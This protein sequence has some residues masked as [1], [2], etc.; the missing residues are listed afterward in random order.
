MKTTGIV[1][2]IVILISGAVRADRPLEKKE[3]SQILQ[4]LTS[5][6]MKA[7]I[8]SGTISAIHEEYRAPKIT[9][10]G[11][12]NDRI[13][14]AIREHQNEARTS[15]LSAD[16]LKM[17]LDAIPFNVRYELSNE[18]TMNSD[19][20]I[21]YDGRRFYWEIDVSSRTDSVKPGPELEG[22]FMT[23][24][25]DLADNRQRA[26]A[27][28]GSKYTLYSMSKNSAFV[29]AAGT[30]PRAVNGPLTAAIIPW[31]YGEYRYANLVGLEFSAVEKQLNGQAQIHLTFNRP[32]GSRMLFALNADNNYAVISHSTEGLYKTVSRQFSNYQR[33]AGVPV[34]RTIEI[35]KRDAA[36]NRL[37]SRDSWYITSISTGALSAGDFNINY[38]NGTQIEYN[39]GILARTAMYRYSPRLDT[40]LLLAERLSYAVSED[41]RTRNCATAA[42]RYAALRLG[43][44]IEDTQLVGLVDRQTGRTS[45]LAMKEFVHRQGLYC[46]AVKTDIETLQ[47]LTD[48]EVILHIPHKN[49]FVLLGDIDSEF[50]WT[51]DLAGRKFC[52]RT[53]VAF[54]GMDWT[55]GVALLISDRPNEGNLDDIADVALHMLN[56]GAGHACTKLLQ[57]FYHEHCEYVMSMCAS[58]YIYE[59]ERLGCEA[60]ESGMC[61]ESYKLQRASCPCV[62]DPYDPFAC[63]INGDWGFQYMPACY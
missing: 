47:R 2:L 50:I 30:L 55:E 17:K 60:A 18:Y 56:G 9:D 51:I 57:N 32:N 10:A 45:L 39:S 14:E 53:D 42:L 24:E 49:H 37:L 36:T 63:I 40:D 25:F 3:I 33:V 22:N 58:W 20:T 5:R 23:N 38:K 7:W 34:P 43:R 31:G 4:V 1:F 27:W 15:Q 54:F 44:N 61:I 52:S 29:D 41:K 59:P 35:E 19:V 28:D 48:C 6:P 21:K 62:E 12:I 8:S 26:F 46:R 13:K 11:E 16:I